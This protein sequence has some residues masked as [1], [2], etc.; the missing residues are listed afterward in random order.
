MF[1]R[2]E[3]NRNVVFLSGWPL[4]VH[5]IS[6][7]SVDEKSGE[8]KLG[9]ARSCAGLTEETRGKR[10]PMSQRESGPERNGP[11][12]EIRLFFGNAF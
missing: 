7:L 1:L 2:W 3:A 5:L 4:M 10:K 8:D 11:S 9:L 6:F 12:A